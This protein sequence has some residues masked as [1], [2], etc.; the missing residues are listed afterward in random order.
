MVKFVDPGQTITASDLGLQDLFMRRYVLIDSVLISCP[1]F[2]RDHLYI[3][4]SSA[5]S[6]LDLRCFFVFFFQD[7]HYKNKPIQIYWKFY[8]QKIKIFRKEFWYF[9]CF[10]SKHR[11]WVLVRTA[12][13]IYVLSRNKSIPP[14]HPT[15]TIKK[16]RFKG[17]KII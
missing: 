15:F 7:T 3:M 11:L 10:C 6:H 1:P 5:A 8:H 14:V 2:L 16:V 9:S 13:A 4:H 12:S 17:V